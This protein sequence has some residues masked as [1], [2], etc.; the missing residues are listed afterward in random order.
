MNHSREDPLVI[1]KPNRA[2]CNFGIGN[3]DIVFLY[4][5]F[6]LVIPVLTTGDY[7]TMWISDDKGIVIRVAMFYIALIIVI[8]NCLF[9]LFLIFRTAGTYYFYNDRM[10]LHAQWIRKKIR[11]PYR[12]MYV[13]RR[14]NGM[15]ITREK[16][17]DGFHPLKHFKILYDV[18]DPNQHNGVM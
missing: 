10:E 14:I 9:W 18:I 15:N 5:I 17:P 7:A 8:P 1:L 16:I 2:W 12:E 6:G 3:I 4:A 11:M 13:I